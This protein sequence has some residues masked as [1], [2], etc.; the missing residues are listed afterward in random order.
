[1]NAIKLAMIWIDIY[2]REIHVAG[3]D[4]ALECVAHQP[5]INRIIE[6]RITAKREIH[7][8]RGLQRELRM[9]NPWRVAT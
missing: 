4:E 2:Y 9:A 7:R 8:L 6:S 1:M 3:C 5:T